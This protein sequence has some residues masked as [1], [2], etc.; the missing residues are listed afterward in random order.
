VNSCVKD[1]YNTGKYVEI[2]EVGGGREVPEWN[3]EYQNRNGSNHIIYL[4]S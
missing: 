2:G 3:A 4:V 1:V